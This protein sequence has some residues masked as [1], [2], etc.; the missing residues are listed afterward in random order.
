M[1]ETSRLVTNTGP[2]LALIA[3]TGDLS[4][5]KSLYE[6]VLVPREVA[7]EIHAGGPSG[8]GVQRFDETSWLSV[9]PEY[10]SVSPYLANTLDRGEA[11]VIQLA[12][13]ESIGVV[14]IDETVGRRVARLNNLKVTGS[15]GVLLRARRHGLIPDI[16]AA[17]EN[18]RRA[19]I[20]V[21]Q[22]VVNTALELDKRP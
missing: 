7:D 2:L 18:M 21:S 8:F 5:L 4:L 13:D 19:G 22:K 12:L 11:A 1:P 17:I 9:H 16:G 14:C 10:L 6:K 3:A 15:I 20:W